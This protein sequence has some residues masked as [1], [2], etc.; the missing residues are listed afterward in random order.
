MQNM[1]KYYKIFISTFEIISIK[2]RLFFYNK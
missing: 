2:Y 1:G